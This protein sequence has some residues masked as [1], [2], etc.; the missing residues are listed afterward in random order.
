[1]GTPVYT[2]NAY[3]PVSKSFGLNV[4]LREATSGQAFPQSVFDHWVAVPG[5]MFPVFQQH[6]RL[7][8]KSMYTVSEHNHGCILF[9]GDDR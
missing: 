4:A 3:L 8:H 7:S 2:I 5:C 6:L 9:P 1:M